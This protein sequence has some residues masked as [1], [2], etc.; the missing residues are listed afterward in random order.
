ML[1][2][3]FIFVL[4]CCYEYPKSSFLS[5]PFEKC[6]PACCVQ[7]IMNK[8]GPVYLPQR[9]GDHLSQFKKS[10]RKRRGHEENLSDIYSLS[11]WKWRRL[12]EEE[13]TIE[14]QTL[15]DWLRYH[16]INLEIQEEERPSMRI[17]RLDILYVGELHL[18]AKHQ[19]DTILEKVY[20]NLL[21]NTFFMI[22]FWQTIR[23]L[24]YD[25]LWTKPQVTILKKFM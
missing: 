17:N 9:S 1:L 14:N 22:I 20:D 3:S 6:A 5:F 7:I 19:S 23:H 16:L 21:A 24:L 12:L 25:N 2:E 8:I 15:M 18:L 13:N 11:G 4:I 10:R